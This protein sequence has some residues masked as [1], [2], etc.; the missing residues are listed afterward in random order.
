[1]TMY[2]VSPSTPLSCTVT[3]PGWLRPAVALASRSKRAVAGSSRGTLRRSMVFT[4]TSRPSTVS[5]PRQ[6]SPI[7]PCPMGSS[8]T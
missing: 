8:R 4:A 1:M 2:A 7:P 6:T 3:T 5:V